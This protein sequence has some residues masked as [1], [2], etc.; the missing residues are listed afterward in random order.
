MKP[1]FHI[2][3]N[4]AAVACLAIGSA[5]AQD[6][7]PVSRTTGVMQVALPAGQVTLLAMPLTSIVASG[8]IETD[9][10]TNTVVIRSHEDFTDDELVTNGYY[11]IKITSRDDQRGTGANAPA[12]SST[13]AYG[14]ASLIVDN[15]ASAAVPMTSFNTTSLDLADVLNPN[16]G[17]EFVIYRVRTLAAGVADGVFGTPAPIANWN[18][19]PSPSSADI[20]YIDNGAGALIGYFHKSGGP[21]GNGWRLASDPAG[22]DQD[23][24]EIP[25]GRAVMVR[26]RAG[27]AASLVFTGVTTVGRESS[28]VSAGYSVLNNPFTVSTTLAASGIQSH[29]TGAATPSGADLLYIESAG[30]LTG[31]FYNSS[32]SQWRLVTAPAGVNQGSVALSPGKSFLFKEQ[33]GAVGFAFPEPFA[34]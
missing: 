21:G 33:A 12:G 31:Y 20:V 6:Q 27:T 22:A 15:A 3:F 26:R 25:A 30:V 14:K 1:H 11:A 23:N 8:T 13:N 2:L 17:D 10:G 28:T 19:A 32:A 16:N 34:E 18:S 4:A 29:I 5:S 9:T 24:V 7:L